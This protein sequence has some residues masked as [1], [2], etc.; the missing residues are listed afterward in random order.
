MIWDIPFVNVIYFCEFFSALQIHFNFMNCIVFSI[1]YDKRINLNQTAQD[2]EDAIRKH[3]NIVK[4]RC[5]R[6]HSN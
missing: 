1:L 4:R 5:T 3:V 2:K 6:T